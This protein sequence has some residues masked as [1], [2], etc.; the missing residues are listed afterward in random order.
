MKKNF[1]FYALICVLFLVLFN[2]IAFITPAL[3]NMEKYNSSFWIGYSFVT[4]GFIG[5]FIC[6]WFVLKEDNA[7]KTFYK[8]SL[9]K[10]SYV[11]LISTFVVGGLCMAIP[12]IPYWMAAICCSLFLVVNIFALVKA[13]MSVDYVSLVE[14]NV[15]QATSFIYCMRE[16]SESLFAR[17]KDGETKG[18][19]KKV[20]E[21]F[22]FSDP[23]SKA[24][25]NDI[26]TEIKNNFE[27]LKSAVCELEVDVVK[28]KA[29]EIIFLV[30]VRNNKCKSTK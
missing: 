6:A 29:E 11:G 10:T 24:D 30:S 3:A 17:A 7:K 19:C 5:E 14:K 22:R 1:K 27:L 9:L 26:E 2:L 15:E 20:C 8:I 16:E 25:L 23:M 21:V 13:K 18:I 28:E 12:Q 4:I